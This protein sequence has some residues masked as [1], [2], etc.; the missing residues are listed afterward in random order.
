MK[1]CAKT[2]GSGWG[3]R[4]A[5]IDIGTNSILLLI[6]DVSRDGQIIPVID[7]QRIPRL[8]RGLDEHGRLSA[9]SVER[10]LSVL[11]EY[12]SI[13]DAY[14]VDRVVAVGT[15]A[16]REASN[17]ELLLDAARRRLAVEIEIIS[18]EDEAVWTYRGAVSGI[19]TTG[20]SPPRFLAIDIGGGSTEFTIGTA[21]D[22]LL[23]LSTPLGAVRVAEKF[24]RSDP[25]SVAEIETAMDVIRAALQESRLMAAG[26]RGLS[27]VGIGGTVTTLA[28][29]RQNL[30]DYD[31]TRIEG[32]TLTRHDVEELSAQLGRMKLEEIRNIPQVSAG[33]E[34]VLFAGSLILRETMRFFDIGTLRVSDRGLRYGMILR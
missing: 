32:F 21:T 23:A 27:V 16:L 1:N 31:P 9:D 20:E 12:R 6:A 11:S 14:S 5:S 2:I 13:V 18:G 3:L 28:A 30:R 29:I 25:P 15:R 8:G 34:D 4:C 19:T 24:F 7:L 33:R 22:V 26:A 10:A 17:P